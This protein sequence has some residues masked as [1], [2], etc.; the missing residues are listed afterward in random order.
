MKTVN[1]LI[2]V[3]LSLFLTGCGETAGD[4]SNR[5]ANL[6][7]KADITAVNINKLVAVIN[8]QNQIISILA[9]KVEAYEEPGAVIYYDEEE[10]DCESPAQTPKKPAVKP[11]P[12]ASTKAPAAIKSKFRDDALNIV[13]FKEDWCPHCRRYMAALKDWHD[14]DLNFVVIDT[15]KEPGMSKF[16]K[17]NGIPETQIYSSSGEFLAVES[18][19]SDKADF[20]KWFNK[21]Q[22]KR[23]R[24]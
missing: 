7:E 2:C 13:I 6:E 24:T 21:Y 20:Q 10:E 17:K 16:K 14:V 15:T 22:T 3:F 23:T 11:S 5:L 19:F 9:A 4:F 1:L 18:G 8:Q 12:K